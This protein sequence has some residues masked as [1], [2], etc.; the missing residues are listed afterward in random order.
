MQI[1]CLIIKPRLFSK[2]ELNILLTAKR[3]TDYH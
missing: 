2:L 3:F 1:Q